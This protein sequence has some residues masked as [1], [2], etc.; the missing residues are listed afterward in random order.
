MTRPL[1]R[2]AVHHAPYV[3]NIDLVTQNRA[4]VSLGNF[5]IKHR[6][7]SVDRASVP[8]RTFFNGDWRRVS[9]SNS[10]IESS[11]RVNTSKQVFQTALYGALVRLKC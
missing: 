11:R 8:R 9:R 3:R 2:H 10:F 5:C 7:P 6:S 1:V 4:K